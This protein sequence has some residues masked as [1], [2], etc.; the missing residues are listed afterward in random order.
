ML[1]MAL[2]FCL[3]AIEADAATYGDL[4]YTVSDG[5]VTITDC[6]TSA[7]SVT[8][9]D[10]IDGY[11]VTSIGSSAFY[12]CTSLET[13]YYCGTEVQWSD[14]RIRSNNTY[15]TDAARFYHKH[16]D[17]EITKTHQKGSRAHFLHSAS[18]ILLS[19]K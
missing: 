11:P 19:K 4:T 16:G 18:L 1:G 8:I 13:V 9:A 12:N 6:N 2:F 10:T 5:K 17:W 14:I 3:P 7:A 15:L